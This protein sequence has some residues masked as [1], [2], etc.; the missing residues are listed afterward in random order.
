LEQTVAD[1]LA[2]NA[3]VPQEIQAIKRR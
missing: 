2:A 1:T 3:D